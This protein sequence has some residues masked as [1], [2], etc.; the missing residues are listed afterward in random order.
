[1]YKLLPNQS[2]HRLNMIASNYWKSNTGY[3][4]SV[5]TLSVRC[6]SVFYML[7]RFY[8]IT[9]CSVHCEASLPHTQT[10]FSR[11]TLSIVA[12]YHAKHIQQAHTIAYCNTK[13]MKVCYSCYTHTSSSLTTLSIVASYHAGSFSSSA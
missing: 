1:M 6:S 8:H 11:T 4:R 10:S 9:T 5:C 12:S 3:C 2:I 7:I 13:V